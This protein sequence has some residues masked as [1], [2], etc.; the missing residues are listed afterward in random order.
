MTPPNGFIAIKSSIIKLINLNKLDD[1]FFFETDILFRCSLNE[2]RICEIPMEAKYRNESSNLSPIS[3][4][5]NFFFRHIS[6][7]FKRIIY[8]YFIYDFNPGSISFLI[9]VLFGLSAILLGGFYFLRGIWNQ[10]E[11]P[12]GIQTLFLALVLIS[13]QFFLNFIYYDVAQ[14][15]L[16]RKLR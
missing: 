5:P 3:E 1:R 11:T 13:S 16:Y 8:H 10:L 14:K 2:V 4:I 7:L 9:S 15:P 6:I 12:A